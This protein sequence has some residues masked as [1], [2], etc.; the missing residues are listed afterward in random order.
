VPGDA[1]VAGG[2]LD[3]QVRVLAG[4]AYRM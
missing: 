3:E 2:A 1:A 4:V